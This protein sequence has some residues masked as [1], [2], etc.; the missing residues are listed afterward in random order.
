MAKRKDRQRRKQDKRA[1][2]DL[3][4]AKRRGDV[5]GLITAD[6]APGESGVSFELIA[7]ELELCHLHRDEARLL[8]FARALADRATLFT[9]HDE[10]RVQACSWL[11]IASALRARQWELGE[12]LLASFGASLA[13]RS[14][15]LARWCRAYVEHRGEPPTQTLRELVSIAAPPDS[16]QT[17]APIPADPAGLEQALLAAGDNLERVEAIER[18]VMR[19]EPEQR[20]PLLAITAQLAWRLALG[21]AVAKRAR[22][23]AR[24]L[25][26]LARAAD[27]ITDHELL[28]RAI[29]L[30][31]QLSAPG[32]LPTE[33]ASL[34][35]TAYRSSA[36]GPFVLD[37]LN[38]FPAPDHP[39]NVDCEAPL[40][41]GRRLLRVRSNGRLWVWTLSWWSVGAFEHDAL[42]GWLLAVGARLL[43]S[44]ALTRELAERVRV[45]A[46]TSIEEVCAA[47]SWLDWKDM[48]KF[49][50]QALE[51]VHGDAR[52]HLARLTHRALDEHELTRKSVGPK[53]SQVKDMILNIERT[54]ASMRSN[55]NPDDEDLA[56]ELGEMLDVF[57]LMPPNLTVPAD[58]ADLDLLVATNNQL[59]PTQRAFVDRHAAQLVPHDVQLWFQL[60]LDDR[61][62]E[63]GVEFINLHLGDAPSLD[64]V[65]RVILIADD[66]GWES[67]ATHGV[68]V[69][70]RRFSDQALA[71]ARALDCFIDER[72]PRYATKPI[73]VALL[74]ALDQRGHAD[75][76]APRI[77]RLAERHAGVRRRTAKKPK[78]TTAKKTTAKKTTTKKAT[79]KKATTKKAATK[80]A[81]TKK[82]ATKKATAKKTTAKKTTA[83]KTTAKKQ[84]A[85]EPKS[86]SKKRA[87]TPPRQG[88]LFDWENS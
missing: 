26:V 82:A 62:R 7:A 88:E 20:R 59:G 83:K 87:Q 68:G 37:V 45:D 3:E 52:R 57:R 75:D 53:R 55:P 49:V 6:L 60:M 38:N 56:L 12:G 17:A 14:P 18:Q 34:L 25:V 19:L 80:K 22:P 13:A 79:A 23:S 27:P 64:Q 48:L 40:E 81:T 71:L 11:L 77:V 47:V 32:R 78:K 61:L 69:L 84:A 8:G 33:L 86:R 24:A 46:Q 16:K 1:A 72:A 39:Y 29:R 67:L 50:E 36:L 54:L 73:A 51:L 44:G 30:A 66:H 76:I 74:A 2:R 21:A 65:L 9:S 85:P 42:P 70:L 10:A 4:K 5:L 41:L 58:F 28:I 35:E 63:R 43:Q 15:E 31:R